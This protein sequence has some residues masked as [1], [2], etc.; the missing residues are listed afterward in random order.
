MRSKL[1]LSLFPCFVL[2]FS[3][4]KKDYVKIDKELIEDYLAENGLT[5]TEITPE[6]I[7]YIEETAGTGIHPNIDNSVTVDYEGF[8]LDGTKFDSSI[9]RGAP[10]TFPLQAV[11]PG[12]QIG[13]PLFKRGGTGKL[14]IPSALAYGKNPPKGSEI[15]CNEVLLFDVHL[16]DIQ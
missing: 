11:I 5:A 14:L 15:K 3:A 8:L 6:G 16:I 9:D 4:C 13:I 1:L 10:A 12:W 7:Y 2:V